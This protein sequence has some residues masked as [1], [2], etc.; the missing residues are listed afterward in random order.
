[1]LHSLGEKFILGGDFNAKHTH[2]GSRLN[3]NKGKQLYAATTENGSEVLSTGRPTY[4][5][6][7]PRRLPDLIDFFIVRKISSNYVKVEEEVDL[8]SD[9]TA[10][11]LTLSDNIILRESK[12]S[13]TNR[14]TNW[15]GFQNFLQERIKL[16]VP[17]KT[18]EHLEEKG[19]LISDIQQ[20][21]WI[22]TAE[23]KK[24]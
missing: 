13:L 4:W 20:A 6:T 18:K 17:L 3:T 9:Y 22:N 24:Q 14:L 19:K 12:P 7:D 11:S 2:W 8:S 21:A 1:M 5:P 15:Q 10:I 16:N 23:I